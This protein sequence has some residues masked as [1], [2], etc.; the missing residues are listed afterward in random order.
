MSDHNPTAPLHISAQL[1]NA[2]RY[3][4]SQELCDEIENAFRAANQHAE[5]WMAL[6]QELIDVLEECSPGFVWGS[7]EY[8]RVERLRNAVMQKAKDRLHVL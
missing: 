2:M 3:K 7:G 8:C 6:V 4:I 5:P 1:E